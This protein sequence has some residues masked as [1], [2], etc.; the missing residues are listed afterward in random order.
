MDLN[1]TYQRNGI[2]KV[3]ADLSLQPAHYPLN[4]QAY[5]AFAHS[6]IERKC[7]S[8]ALQLSACVLH[9]QPFE[10]HWSIYAG[11]ALFELGQAKKAIEVVFSSESALGRATFTA[12]L[13]DNSQRLTLKNLYYSVCASAIESMGD[14]ETS[15]THYQQ[16]HGLN[17]SDFNRLALFANFLQKHIYHDTDCNLTVIERL[18]K[19]LQ[20]LLVLQPSI[21]KTV[22]GM[23]ADLATAIGDYATAIDHL[24][25]ALALGA[26]R[27][28]IEEMLGYLY[29][30]DLQPSIGF[31]AI[32]MRD[33]N[34]KAPAFAQPFLEVFRVS[35][36]A[37]LRDR[38]VERVALIFEQG[39][40]DQLLYLQLVAQFFKH[41][42]ADTHPT[43]RIFVDIFCEL[44]MV[45]IVQLFL[46]QC[47]IERQVYAISSQPVDLTQV[48]ITANVWLADLPFLLGAKIEPM[49]WSS[50][51]QLTEEFT[52]NSGYCYSSSDTNTSSLRVGVNWC[53][54]GR[55]GIRRKD[56]PLHAFKGL[57]ERYPNVD[58]ISVQYGNVKDQINRFNDTC[59]NPIIL[60]DVDQFND[61]NAAFAQIASLDCLITSSSSAAH[62][63]GVLGIPCVVILP[64]VPL[65]Y[66]CYRQGTQS[67]IYPSVTLLQR[68]TIND[69]SQSIALVQ[70]W[71]D[72]FISQ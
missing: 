7:Y 10:L 57:F 29:L 17:D 8:D 65:W 15:V 12:E 11:K 60:E 22:M 66:W 64:F 1:A 37:Q 67:L 33:L 45:G 56:I 16:W 71:L 50:A 30:S 25:R 49:V 35:E 52:L 69:I 18:P 62:I 46:E 32:L 34:T 51:L 39:V 61:L 41:I 36:L 20:T 13:L 43:S 19:V 48:P 38:N 27:Q 9:I 55:K 44:K 47:G 40:G 72:E 26:E 4:A 28:K 14:F 53:G 3:I 24:Q 59:L 58:F 42:H 68:P 6:L 21:E 2:Q 63:A 54:P 31:E 70:R 23:I 5:L